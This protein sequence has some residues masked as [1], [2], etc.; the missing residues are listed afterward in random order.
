MAPRNT[1]SSLHG[2][3]H[4]LVAPVVHMRASFRGT[5]RRSDCRMSLSED[6][7]LKIR[8]GFSARLMPSSASLPRRIS[9]YLLR[10]MSPLRADF[11]AEVI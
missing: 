4:R 1:V 9:P 7:K 5:R 11:V 2:S 10:C 3:P 8:D 6:K